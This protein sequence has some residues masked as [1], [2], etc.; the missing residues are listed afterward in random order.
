MAHRKHKYHIN[1]RSKRSKLLRAKIESSKIVISTCSNVV[2]EET[3]G[4][5]FDRLLKGETI[6]G[7]L[8]DNLLGATVRYCAYTV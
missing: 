3:N 8:F 6:G 2:E 7:K 4:E 5:V 1:K